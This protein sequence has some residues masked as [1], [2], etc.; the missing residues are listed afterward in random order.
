MRKKDICNLIISHYRGDDRD[1][2]TQTLDIMKEFKE[3]GDKELVDM[4]TFEVLSKVKVMPKPEVIQRDF[5]PEISF[6]DYNTFVPQE[7]E[8]KQ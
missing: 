4:L 7:Q 6:D 5:T 2:F 1:F 3:D 8:S